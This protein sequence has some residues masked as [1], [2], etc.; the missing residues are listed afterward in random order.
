MTGDPFDGKK[1]AEMKLINYA[2]P[3]EKLREETDR[4]GAKADEE[5]PA[6]AARC[7]GSLQ[8]LPHHG[9]QPGWKNT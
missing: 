4:P 6:G 1:A 3:K 8:V 7:Q 2:V 9:L 5:E